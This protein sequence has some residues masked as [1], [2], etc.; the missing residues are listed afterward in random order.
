MP[1][2]GLPVEMEVWNEMSERNRNRV[3]DI[4]RSHVHVRLRVAPPIHVGGL[5]VYVCYVIGLGSVRSYHPCS[6]HAM[7]WKVDGGR[8][9][10]W[11]KPA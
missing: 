11:R 2:S 10:S 7:V 9:E 8:R 3:Q 1:E 4:A 6:I 5:A